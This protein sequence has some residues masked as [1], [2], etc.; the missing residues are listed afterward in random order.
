MPWYRLVFNLL[1]VVLLIP[2]LGYMW[3][4]PGTPLWEWHGLG[5]WFANALSLVAVGGFIWS[6]RFYDSGEFLGLR[7]LRM[8]IR[9]IEDQEHFHISPLHRY[10]RHPLYSLGLIIIWTQ[11]MDPARL[12]SAC[13]ISLYLIVGSR[14]EE[15]KLLVFHGDIYREYQVLV[16]SLIPS[17]RRFLSRAQ[18]E[19]LLTRYGSIVG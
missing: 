4:L 5:A 6:L 11:E 14:L 7:Q 8:A 15:R 1:A 13:L 9:D 17:P 3:Y 10:V 19:A 18:A 16:P 12:L 2:P